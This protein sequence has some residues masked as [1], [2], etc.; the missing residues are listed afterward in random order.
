MNVDILSAFEESLRSAG[1][2]VE[3][4]R[5]DG[6][7]HRCGTTDRPRGKDGAYRI[8]LDAPACC[9]WK[10]W[11][12]GDEGSRT[13]KPDKDLT[14]A[15][16]KA[17]RERIAAA[18]KEAEE[19]QATRWAASAKLARAIW[20]KA[21][22]ASDAHPYLQRKGIPALA[23]IRQ[24]EWR[25]AVELVLPVLDASGQLVSLQFIM[26]EK[27]ADGPDKRFLKGGRTAGGYFPIPAK[28]GSKDG[29]LLI[30]EGYATAASLHLATGHTCLVAFNAGNLLPV[31]RMA[32]DKYPDREIILCADND[33]G[34]GGDRNPGVEAA[35]R[36]ARAIG[37]KLAVCP[38]LDGSK[39]DFNDLHTARSLEAVR[40]VIE[41][42]RKQA[43]AVTLP[44][45]GKAIVSNI[46]SNV[47]VAF[48]VSPEGVVSHSQEVLDTE[49][50]KLVSTLHA[51][52]VGGFS[53][54]CPGVDGGRGKP[55][56]LSGFS[57][58]D[59]VL[60]PG[61]S[62]N[63]GYILE[64]AADTARQEQ[65]ILECLAAT[66]KDDRKAEKYLAGWTGHAGASRGA[67]RRRFRVHRPTSRI[68]GTAAPK[69]RNRL[70]LK[71]PMRVRHS[72]SSIA[73]GTACRVD[74]RARL[75][76]PL[77]HPGRCAAPDDGGGLFSR[78]NDF[79]AGVPRGLLAIS[80]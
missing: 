65:M 21:G 76:F 31:A 74:R 67:G 15:E 5:A 77:L 33:C 41:E 73:E 78:Q 14:P 59:Y 50:G 18:R 19:E 49:T 66:V 37:G 28:D 23:G 53:W 38:A 32:R 51:S 27:P 79:R 9:W 39:A 52:R 58:F 56:R 57:G 72:G 68:D 10:N 70:H 63:Q 8:H 36:A 22:R 17:L 62:S 1:L 60:N 46:P 55:T 54:A 2:V 64:G 35:T 71:G 25:G 7:L 34:G 42:A 26:P 13:A 69:R 6:H 48:D 16:R 11:R 24:R 45:G 75:L 43:P 3:H 12:S 4:V 61:F 40:M 30:A 29:P 20:D 47:I 44:D 80:H